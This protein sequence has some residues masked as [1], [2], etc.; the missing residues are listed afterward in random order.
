MWW[1]VWL[2][3]LPL[4]GL[5]LLEMK[6][7]NLGKMSQ[8]APQIWHLWHLLS[9]VW[10]AVWPCTDLF[11]PSCTVERTKLSPQLADSSGHLDVSGNFKTRDTCATLIY[12][13]PS[14][15]LALPLSFSHYK[16]G[17]RQ[18][19]GPQ[20]KSWIKSLFEAFPGIHLQ[21]SLS[22][23]SLY[24]LVL[25]LIVTTLYWRENLIQLLPSLRRKRTTRPHLHKQ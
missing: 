8:T 4:V 16:T 20:V 6:S 9:K 14:A 17:R 13:F 12:L 10:L 11:S 24:L 15:F 7:K 2:I 19:S 21:D 22:L 3:Q 18:A 1:G 25:L 5:H 23:S